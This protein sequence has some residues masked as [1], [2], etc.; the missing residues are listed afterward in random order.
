VPTRFRLRTTPARRGPARTLSIKPA[1]AYQLR[2]SGQWAQPS[3]CGRWT[4]EEV[5]AHLTAAASV[6][7]VRWLMSVLGARLDFDVH[8]ARRLAEHRGATPVQTLERFRRIISSS[9]AASGHTSA[10]LGEVVVHAQDVRRPLGLPRVPPT[11]AVTEVARFYA[12][13]DFTVASRST[14]EG[15]RLE[16]TDGP[17]TTGTGPLVTGTTLALTMA[18]AG[19]RAYCDDLTGPGVPVLR[20]RCSPT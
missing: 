20:E 19:R 13:R 2:N 9:T 15:L 16:A 11:E 18:M 14:A 12:S 6:G 10:W 5:V 4:V 8:N 17:F 7:R 3:L 1:S